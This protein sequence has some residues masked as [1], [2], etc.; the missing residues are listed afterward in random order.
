VLG[1]AVRGLGV[2]GKGR[3]RGC[4][5]DWGSDKA[6]G[7]GEGRVEHPANMEGCRGGLVGDSSFRLGDIRSLF[8][9]FVRL[10]A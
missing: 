7:I 9:P 1:C 10:M 4:R 5:D 2:A 6:G 3:T 8:L